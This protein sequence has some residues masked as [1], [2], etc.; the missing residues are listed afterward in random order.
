MGVPLSYLN[1]L[2]ALPG[3]RANSAARVLIPKDVSRRLAREDLRR[4]LVIA[5][6]PDGPTE[7]MQPLF[8]SIRDGLAKLGQQHPGVGFQLTGTDVVARASVNGMI[9]DLAV[10]LAFAALLIFG[11]I[12]LEFRS[13]RL[14]LISLL[15]NLF[16]LALVGGVLYAL[17]RPLQMSSAVLFTV[18]LGLAVDDTIHFLSRY[19]RELHSSPNVE[20]AVRSAFFSVGRAI[21]ITTLVLMLGFGCLAFSAVPLNQ[22]FAGLACL[23]LAGALLGDLL[24][25]PALLVLF[26]KKSH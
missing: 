5:A 3:G 4:A 10:S 21:V 26:E 11:V 19:R 23:G 8:R 15:P 18:L 9:S 14:G 13:L 20:H 24:L 25:L 17:G 7:V 6:V 12:S 22:L 16:P 1:L 2:D